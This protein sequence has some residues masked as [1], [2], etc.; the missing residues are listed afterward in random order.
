ME[1]RESMRSHASQ[2]LFTVED[3]MEKPYKMLELT[4][5]KGSTSPGKMLRVLQDDVKTGRSG[6]TTG[7]SSEERSC[8]SLWPG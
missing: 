2:V 3:Y 8:C 7:L 6:S 5:I 4:A 1:T